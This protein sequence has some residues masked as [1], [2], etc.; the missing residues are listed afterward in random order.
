MATLVALAFTPTLAKIA[1]I[2]PNV[3]V[4]LMLPLLVIS[5]VM[6]TDA[7]ENLWVVVFFGCLGW[8][9]KRYGWPR[10][11]ILIAVA[12]AR[13]L[14][15]YLSLSLNTYGAEMLLRPQVIILLGLAAA[16]IWYTM[17]LQ[18]RAPVAVVADDD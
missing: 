7:I 11:P 18:Q 3:L 14:E 2:P 15:K 17:R 10:P 16:G 4:P 13:S 9:M 1:T 12:L 5:T 6:G 8:F